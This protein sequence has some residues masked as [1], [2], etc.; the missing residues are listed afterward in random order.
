VKG[1][2]RPCRTGWLVSDHRHDQHCSTMAP[3]VAMWAQDHDDNH[4]RT[5]TKTKTRWPSLQDKIASFPSLRLTTT[6][7]GEPTSLY[8]A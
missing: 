5:Y 6:R 1:T 3:H 8:V 4:A 7:S 2:A